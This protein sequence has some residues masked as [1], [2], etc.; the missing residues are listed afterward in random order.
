M[1]L[2][3]LRS[4]VSRRPGWVVGS[5]FAVAIAVGLLSPD[6]TRLAA[7]GQAN[8]LTADSSQSLRTALE[9][10][11]DWPDQYY[12]ALAIVALHRPAGL[13]EADRAYAR[14]LS[15]R[16]VGPGRP[17]EVLRVVG[18]R[19]EPEIAGRLVSRDGTVELMAVHLSK[20]FVSPATQQ[21]VAW[22]QSRPKAEGLV[23]PA[24][25]EVQWSGDAV[26]GLDYMA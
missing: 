5:W 15:D 7:E 14:R 20:P 18:P 26:L 25:L 16:I 8:L 1:P 4:L 13:T 21:A 11:R 23:P 12:E 2:D 9:A 17:G 24:G 19:S 6:L 22:L 10:G 3:S